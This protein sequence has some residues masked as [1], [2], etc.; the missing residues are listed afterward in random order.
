M[1]FPE[2]WRCR[3]PCQDLVEPDW[4]CNWET[5]HKCL[6]GHKRALILSISSIILCGVD[7]TRAGKLLLFIISPSLQSVTAALSFNAGPSSN[8]CSNML[9]RVSHIPK[10]TRKALRLRNVQQ[11]TKRD[12]N[13]SARHKGQPLRVRHLRTC[14]RL[15]YVM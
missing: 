5:G 4:E 8:R 10:H 13:R 3:S 1:Q 6:S 9:Y 15:G 2:I 14:R 12:E 7:I 11:E